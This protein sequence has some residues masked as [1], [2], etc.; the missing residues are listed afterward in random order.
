MSLLDVL[1]IE[2][3]GFVCILRRGATRAGSDVI[4]LGRSIG[5]WHSALRTAFLA[6]VSIVRWTARLLHRKRRIDKI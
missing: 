3:Q 1:S 5:P 4:L 6:G 2:L